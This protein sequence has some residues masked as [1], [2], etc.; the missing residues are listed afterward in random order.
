MCSV[1]L[2]YLG[3]FNMAKI[4]AVALNIQQ[5][6]WKAINCCT[7][8]YM[9]QGTRVDAAEGPP[10]LNMQPAL[11]GLQRPSREEGESPP[12]SGREVGPIGGG[13]AGT[14]R[15]LLKQLL[16]LFFPC[17]NAYSLC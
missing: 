9:R 7:R 5:Q 3:A 13:E 10:V 11:L 16:E 2:V 8:Q 14:C 4:R 1:S 6:H 17:S 12:H 15:N